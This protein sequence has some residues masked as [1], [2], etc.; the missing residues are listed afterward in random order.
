MQ[1]E[2]VGWKKTTEGRVCNPLGG[3]ENG[4]KVSS[5]KKTIYTIGSL[6]FAVFR[7]ARL[8]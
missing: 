3:W 5:V 6:N 2:L 1:C 4:R 8:V 7:I